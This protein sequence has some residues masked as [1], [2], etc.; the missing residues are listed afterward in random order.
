ME[1]RQRRVNKY[2]DKEFILSGNLEVPEWNYFIG[3][4]KNKGNPLYCITK[5]I[6]NRFKEIPEGMTITFSGTGESS[7]RHHCCRTFWD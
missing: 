4:P 2:S 6:C 5:S 7:A 1:A 3:N